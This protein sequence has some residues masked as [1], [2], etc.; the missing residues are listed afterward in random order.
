V[1]GLAVVSDTSIVVA[2]SNWNTKK[3]KLCVLSV[4][5]V[6]SIVLPL[7][8]YGY[9]ARV[10]PVYGDGTVLIASDNSVSLFW[11]LMVVD[12]F[13]CAQGYGRRSG[14]DVAT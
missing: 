4:G 14:K 2:V 13:G 11:I 12:Q 7:D 6:L 10:S 8:G 5:R 9:A 1:T 3:Y